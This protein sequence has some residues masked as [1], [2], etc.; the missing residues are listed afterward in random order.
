MR[1]LNLVPSICMGSSFIVDKI[2]WGGMEVMKFLC[3]SNGSHGE[4]TLHGGG[5]GCILG[6]F[7][8]CM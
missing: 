5:G 7:M 3:T 2:G 1:G 6:T 4:N 8:T